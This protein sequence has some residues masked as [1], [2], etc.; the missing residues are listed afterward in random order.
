MTMSRRWTQHHSGA[1]HSPIER[2]EEVA[3]NPLMPEPPSNWP[4]TITITTPL[5]PQLSC[6]SQQQEEME[7]KIIAGV[8]LY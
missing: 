5:S 8:F 6:S 4:R 3:A 7:G 2:Q 1:M